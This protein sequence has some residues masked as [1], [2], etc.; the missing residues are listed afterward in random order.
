[1][2]LR[3]RKGKTWVF[4]GA[5]RV[6]KIVNSAAHN[7]KFQVCYQS[8]YREGHKFVKVSGAVLLAQLCRSSSEAFWPTVSRSRIKV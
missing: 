2:L 5:G 8:S 7:F 1:M 3:V 4:P 6:V